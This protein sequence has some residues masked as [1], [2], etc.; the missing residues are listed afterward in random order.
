MQEFSFVIRET[1]ER[2][3]YVEACDYEQAYD[4]VNDMYLDCEI[5]LDSDDFKGFEIEVY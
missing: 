2:V 4:K 5:V 1:L 3:V